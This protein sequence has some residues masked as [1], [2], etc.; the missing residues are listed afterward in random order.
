MMWLQRQV[1]SNATGQCCMIIVSNRLGVFCCLRVTSCPAVWIS[2][3]W[4]RKAEVGL[5]RKAGE[6]DF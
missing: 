3:F 6:T 1:T 2:L 5:N 4:R